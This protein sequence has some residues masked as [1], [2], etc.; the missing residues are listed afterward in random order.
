MPVTA[1]S[2]G[3]AEAQGVGKAAEVSKRRGYQL[4]SLS[5]MVS[6]SLGVYSAIP[7]ETG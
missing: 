3:K 6:P 4:A 5:S 2:G 1:M 7:A